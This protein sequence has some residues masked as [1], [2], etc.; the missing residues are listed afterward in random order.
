MIGQSDAVQVAVGRGPPPTVHTSLVFNTNT[1][2]RLFV[3]PMTTP[4]VQTNPFQWKTVGSNGAN[5]EAFPTA[6][7]S[8][9]L[10]CVNG[11][12]NEIEVKLLIVGLVKVPQRFPSKCSIVPA[13]P[14]IQPSSELVEKTDV[15]WK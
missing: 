1:E 6:H 8:F 3:A 12:P 9:G 4:F 15:N 11:V 13:V 14:T 7:P 5:A 10:T 2:F